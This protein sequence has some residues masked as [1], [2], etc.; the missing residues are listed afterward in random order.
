MSHGSTIANY[1]PAL[2]QASLAAHYFH[3]LLI[4]L[5]D[6]APPTIIIELASSYPVRQLEAAYAKLLLIQQ[7]EQE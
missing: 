6:L 4:L 5:N 1:V 3:R 7:L 2:E